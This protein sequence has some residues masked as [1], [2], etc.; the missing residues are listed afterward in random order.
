MSDT[1]TWMWRTA[2]NV[3]RVG[4]VLIFILGVAKAKAHDPGCGER[5][6]ADSVEDC[7]LGG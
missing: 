1:H 7:L 4:I 6:M 5:P 2:S 3:I